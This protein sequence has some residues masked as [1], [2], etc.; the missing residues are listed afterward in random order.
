MARLIESEE[1]LKRIRE[2]AM[3]NAIDRGTYETKSE[4]NLGRPVVSFAELCNRSK[5]R[6]IYR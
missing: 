5:R 2:K 1:V 3:K 4:F 6:A